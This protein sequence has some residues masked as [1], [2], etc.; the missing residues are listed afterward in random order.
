[1]IPGRDNLQVINQ[2]INQAQAEQEQTGQRLEELH[3]QLNALRLKAGEY[4]RELA[5]LR[6]DDLKARQVI[7]RLDE[8]DEAVL[9]LLEKLKQTRSSLDEQIS[10]SLARQRQLD[11]QRQEF[12][13]QRDEAGEARQRQLEMTSSRLR[14]TESYRQQEQRAQEAAAVAQHADEKASQAEKDQA[15]KGKPYQTDPLFMYLWNRRHLTPDYHGG[16]LTRR[17]DAWV[18]RLIDFQRNRANYYMLQELPRRLREHATKVQQTAQQEVKALHAQAQKAAAADGLPALETKVQAAI[19]QIKQLDADLD[20]EEARHQK[21]MQEQAGVQAGAD[22]ITK[23][24]LDLEAAALASESLAG[25]Y[26]KARATPRPEDDVVVANL[27]H[28]QQQQEEKQA[29][30]QSLNNLL[31]QRQRDL[32]QLE[33]VRRRYRQ[34]GYDSY[35][36]RFPGNFSLAVLLGQML[37]GMM[38]SDTVWREI[39]RHQQGRSPAE[40]PGRGGGDF[41]GFGGDFGGAGGGEFKTGGGF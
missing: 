13:R 27:Q 20:A 31:Q 5:R 26:Q 23:Q 30:I 22:P 15:E 25:L 37:G 28:L 16:W 19:D 3:R 4:Y 14:D 12:M 21:L 38:N 7:S 39:G 35:D 32:G 1:M 36:S 41:G 10:T 29:E 34:N 8:T 9:Q 33:E 2:H 40:Y 24:I 11:G 18:A 17:L 6:L